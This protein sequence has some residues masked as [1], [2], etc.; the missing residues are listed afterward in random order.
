[1]ANREL[2]GRKLTNKQQLERL[3]TYCFDKFDLASGM[4]DLADLADHERRKEAIRARRWFKRGQQYAQLK[5]W[6]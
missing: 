1:M 4:A 5:D 6:I 2:N 3:T